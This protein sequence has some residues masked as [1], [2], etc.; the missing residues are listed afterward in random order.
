MTTPGESPTTEGAPADAE[1]SLSTA[2]GVPPVRELLETLVVGLCM[3]TADAVPGVS[4]G[5]IALIAGVYERLIAAIT[6]LTPRR[7]LR[8]VAAFLPTDGGFF[9]EDGCRALRELDVWFLGSLGVGVIT[10]VVLVT[11]AVHV[12]DEAAP[13]VLF[14]FF[15]GLIA[16]SALV[17]AREIDLGERAP[18]AALLGGAVVAAVVSVQSAALSG[19][20]LLLVFVGGV[21]GVSA[22]ILPGI[23]GSLLLV[24]LGQYTRLSGELSAFVDAL[25]GLVRGGSTDALFGPGSVVVT[26]VVG[27]VVGL[28][29]ISRVVRGALDRNR[30]V[31]LAALVGL[32]V[33]ALVAPVAEIQSRVGFDLLIAGEFALAAVGGAA[34]VLLLD[35]Y[36]VDLEL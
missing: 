23:S 25:A 5:T 29:T 4:G 3:G 33:G 32:V 36:A 14:G 34:V 2:L 8:A 11:R 19:G 6:A 31:T 1:E 10:A 30:A 17:L 16:A 12:L 20:G 15:F 7:G 24:I 27:G 13:V 9:D 35:R 26:F 21:V 18:A 28:L 22:M